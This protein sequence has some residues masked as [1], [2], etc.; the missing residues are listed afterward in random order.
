MPQTNVLRAEQLSEGALR[1][2][3]FGPAAKSFW[4]VTVAITVV[5][6]VVPVPL[7]PPLPFYSYC[8]FKLISFVTLG[9]IGPLAFRRFNA[10]NRGIL[11]ATISAACVESSQG[12]LHHG[13]SFHWYEMAV[14]LALILLGFALG[15]DACYD[16]RISLGLLQIHLTDKQLRP[17]C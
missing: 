8:V 17:K 14:K 11:L 6:E 1:L 16:R 15:L 4:A 10:L 2:P 9:Y 12:L 13:H 3:A 5:T 7:M